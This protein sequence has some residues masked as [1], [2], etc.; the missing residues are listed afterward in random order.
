M[1]LAL[2]T[3]PQN[4]KVPEMMDIVYQNIHVATK[5]DTSWGI[6]SPEYLEGKPETF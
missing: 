2:I 6:D 1:D 3:T 4:R 5:M